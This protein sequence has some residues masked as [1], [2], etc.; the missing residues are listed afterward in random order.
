MEETPLH[1]ATRGGHI[2]VMHTLL[3]EGAIVDAKDKYQY[4]ALHG[5]AR[6]DRV[7]MIRSLLFRWANADEMNVSGRTALDF[8]SAS[9]YLNVMAVLEA[10]WWIER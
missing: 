5:A 3:A 9:G 4:T 8:A 2:H 6:F 10:P 7:E 1:L